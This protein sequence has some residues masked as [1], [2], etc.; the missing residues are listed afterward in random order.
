[1]LLTQI[2]FI[3]IFMQCECEEYRNPD[4]FLEHIRDNVNL[5]NIVDRR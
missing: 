1:M 4:P 5:R 3:S 2:S